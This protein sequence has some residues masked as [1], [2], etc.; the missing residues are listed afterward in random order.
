M[1]KAGYEI[2][3]WPIFTIFQDPFSGKKEERRL[4]K[5]FVIFDLETMNYL[6]LTLTNISVSSKKPH[7]ISYLSSI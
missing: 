3:V 7:R 5:R 1:K 2:T 4:Q 6:H